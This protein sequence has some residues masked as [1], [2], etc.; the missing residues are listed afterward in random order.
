[1]SEKKDVIRS[2]WRWPETRDWGVP[3]TKNWM[4]FLFA[5][6]VQATPLCNNSGYKNTGG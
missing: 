1:M 3:F 5:S 4:N 2:K 6:E